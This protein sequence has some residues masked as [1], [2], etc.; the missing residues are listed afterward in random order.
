I[1]ANCT[2]LV[3]SGIVLTY[4][5][6]YE[7]IIFI[8]LGLLLVGISFGGAP[9]LTSSFIH[10]YFGEENYTVNF[11]ITNFS[12]I[13]SAIIGPMISSLLLERSSGNYTS[14]F[15]MIIILGIF[16]FILKILLDFSSK[17]LAYNAK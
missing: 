14:T 17:K 11:S 9:S 5:S 15:I 16:A 8:F 4:G 2:T 12:L 3:L 10:S 7:N 1:T 6:T 13:P